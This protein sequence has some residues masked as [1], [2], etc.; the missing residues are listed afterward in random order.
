VGGPRVD[1]GLR[2][3]QN[4]PAR[5]CPQSIANAWDNE[6]QTSYHGALESD[7]VSGSRSCYFSY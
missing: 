7:V 5:I 6:Y 1:R 3:P 4:S 2:A